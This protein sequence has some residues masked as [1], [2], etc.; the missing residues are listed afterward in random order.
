M[1]VA[2]TV[3]LFSHSHGSHGS[4]GSKGSHDCNGSHGQSIIHPG[5]GLH[6][7]NVSGS[8]S[9]GH[10]CHDSMVSPTAEFGM[11]KVNQLSDCQ[12]VVFSVESCG[13]YCHHKQKNNTKD[14]G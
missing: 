6:G 10:D 14:M 13:C 4:H 9:H 12:V 3:A 2:V 5:G 8:N 11:A 7:G 1:A